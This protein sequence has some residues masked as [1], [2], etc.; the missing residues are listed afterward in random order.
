MMRRF[1]FSLTVFFLFTQGITAQVV[2][3]YDTM[4]VEV[5]LRRQMFHDRLDKE[6]KRIDKLDGKVNQELSLSSNEDLN[7]QITDAIL[8]RVDEIQFRIEK[9][10][11][12]ENNAKIRYVTSLE[13]LLIAYGNMVR[14]NRAKASFAPE[15]LDLFQKCMAADMQSASIAPIIAKSSFEA[16]EAITDVFSDNAGGREARKI[17]FLKK[18]AL[19]PRAILKGMT[20]FEGE[21]F[22]DSLLAVAGRKIPMEL[23][24]YAQA[25]R[26]KEGIMIRSSKDV[27]VKTI[28]EL[29]ILPNG[30]LYLPFLDELINGKMQ[31]SQIQAVTENEP[32]YYKL[33]VKTQIAYY[34]RIAAGD[35]PVLASALTDMLQRKATDV[36]VNVMNDLHDATEA[37][38][39]K[40]AENLTPQEIYY[41]IVNTEE[42]IYTSTYTNLYKRMM[43]RFPGRRGDSLLMSIRFDRFKKFIKMAA[44]YN[45][46]DPFL[47]TMPE[48]NNRRLMYAF[49]NGLQ[50]TNSL[51][52]AVDVADSYGS[53]MNRDLQYFLMRQVEQNLE[54]SQKLKDRK[55]EAIYNI[56]YTLFRSAGDSSVNL[57][58]TLGIPPVY[59]LDARSLQDDSGRVVQQVFFY[60]DEDGIMSF[61]SFMGLFNN[62]PDWKVETGKEWVTIRSLK[63]RPTTIYAN[64]P[65]DYKQDLD[66]AAQA[67]LIAYLKAN[68]L[69]PTVVVHRG[70]SYHLKYTLQ[71]MMSSSRIVM[72]GSCGGYQ[73]LSRVLNINNDA[74]I[75]STKQVGTFTVNDPILRILNDYIVNG[76]N[77]EWMNLWQQLYG[78]IK[79]DAVASKYF[80]EYIPPH[81]NLGAIFIKAYRRSMGEM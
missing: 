62:K 3:V 32:Q 54:S 9:D 75:I 34:G 52:D 27:L 33:L 20:V 53:I 8:R 25:V 73:N 30:T 67:N 70:H 11:N 2:L 31:R 81:K 6:Q 76:R 42:V 37:T 57:S 40:I 50:R 12:T 29:S 18:C 71:Q 78:N 7:V 36:F 26:S 44:N 22:V 39:F 55:G 66:A 14:E 45:T 77:I 1:L 64:L 80:N 24:S 16:G 69:H 5:P 46:L 61:R 56:L 21:A 41:L 72:L 19:N 79:S 23:Y 17:I 43:D 47:Q 15:L 28:A 13:K 35:T 65:L 38:R 51:E 59:S 63:G 68:N 49:V 48:L 58:A 10:P 4:K 60:G 74:H